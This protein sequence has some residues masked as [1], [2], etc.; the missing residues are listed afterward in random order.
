MCFRYTTGRFLMRDD[1]TLACGRCS[2]DVRIFR[3]PTLAPATSG[4]KTF[5][6]SHEYDPCGIRTRPGQLE[7][8]ATSPE[9]EW[10]VTKWVVGRKDDICDTSVH[11]RPTYPDPLL[12]AG[13]KALESF[14]PGLRP[15]AKPSQ[16]PARAVFV[17]PPPAAVLA[18]CLRQN[19]KAQCRLRD[20]G[21]FESLRRLE[22]DVTCAGD[23]GSSECRPEV[24]AI[25]T[26]NPVHYANLYSPNC[27]QTIAGNR[28]AR[29][30]LR[31]HL[32]W[33]L[34]CRRQTFSYRPV[35]NQTSA[36]KAS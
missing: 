6:I 34:T 25:P 28:D 14:S 36:V 20:T 16:L 11:P 21:L 29:V 17:I 24:V 18:V 32:P 7:R 13:W 5:V 19:E 2:R 1:E 33:Y 23:A 35:C 10:A 4:C 26:N 15:G 8:L 22:A 3:E 31:A 27:R 9:V 12:R 30:A